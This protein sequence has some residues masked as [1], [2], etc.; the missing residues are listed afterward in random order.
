MKTADAIWSEVTVSAS[1]H[2]STGRYSR[3]TTLLSQFLN[4]P[5]QSTITQALREEALLSETIMGEVIMAESAMNNSN[6]VT[7]QTAN[8]SSE[9]TSG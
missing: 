8:T 4:L 1:K 5:T 7:A 9:I 6:M 2:P 3:L